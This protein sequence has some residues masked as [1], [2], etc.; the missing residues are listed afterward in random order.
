MSRF[1]FEKGDLKSFIQTSEDTLRLSLKEIA[2]KLHISDRTLRDWKREKFYPNNEAIT[3]LSKISSVPLPSH[4][5]Y[6]QYWYTKNAG[7]LGGKTRYALYGPLGN[8]KS[9]AKGGSMS[10]IARKNNPEI[11]KKYLN[12][13]TKPN[14]S[15]EFAELVGILLGDGGIT[16]GQMTIYLSSIT[17]QKYGTYVQNLI[18]MVFGLHASSIVDHKNHVLRISISGVNVVKYLIQKGLRIGNKV[19]LQVGVPQWINKEKKYVRACI[20]GLID[21]DGCFTIHRYL[22]NKK[23]YSYPKIVFSNRSEPILDFVYKGLQRLKYNPKRTIEFD[24]W[25]HSQDEVKR[26]LK[27]IGTNNVKPAVLKIL[28]GGVR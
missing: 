27:D 21:T 19:K 16:H 20:R 1:R 23:K 25:L 24:V 10:W 26:Y 14:K 7:M 17:D 2:K 18:Y 22:V 9:R 6:P 11:W 12:T 13:F 28:A 15:E 8:K 4:H 3:L 5:I